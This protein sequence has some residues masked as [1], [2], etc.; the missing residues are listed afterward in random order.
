M[1]VYRLLVIALVL[2]FI[3]IAC[4]QAPQVDTKA[5]AEKIQQ[6]VEAWQEAVAARDIDACT[7]FYAPDGVEMLS[8]SPAAEGP[9]AIYQW[10]ADWIFDT[11]ITNSFHTD[12]IEVAASGDL[13]YE[14]GTWQF[15]ME[16]EDGPIED[17]GKYVIVWKKIDGEWKALIDIS[18]S[19]IPLEQE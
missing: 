2:S 17:Y 18:N 12:F 19:D 4:A 13:A 9:E 3:T 15:V 10:Y 6:V 1:S 16:T 14:R 8:N 7:S 5:E 11:T